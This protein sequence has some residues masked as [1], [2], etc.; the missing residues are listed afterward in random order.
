MDFSS[1]ITNPAF[2]KDCLTKFESLIVFDNS[3]LIPKPSSK[4]TTILMQFFLP[5]QALCEDIGCR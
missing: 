5:P 4:N 3:E 1:F 2:S